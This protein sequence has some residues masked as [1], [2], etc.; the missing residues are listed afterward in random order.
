MSCWTLRRRA[1]EGSEGAGAAGAAHAG[2][3]RVRV[4]RHELRRAVAVPARHRGASS[5]TRSCL[6][7]FDETLREAMER[8]TELFVDSVSARTAA[9][10]IC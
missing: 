10:S 8:E 7:D 1:A 9:S 6:P 2:G 4:A 5:R 3:P